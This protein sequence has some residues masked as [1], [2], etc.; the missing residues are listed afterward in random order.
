M[1]IL[2]PISGQVE[3]RSIT[4][5][6]GWKQQR[7]SFLFVTTKEETYSLRTV[8]EEANNFHYLHGQSRIQREA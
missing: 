4:I 1:S 3:L 8:V 2:A 7:L 6:L 5:F